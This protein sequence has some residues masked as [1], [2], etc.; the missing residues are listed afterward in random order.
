MNCDRN[1]IYLISS[2]LYYC[3]FSKRKAF[4]QIG[5]L[6]LCNQMQIDRSVEEILQKEIT[7][8]HSNCI[9]FNKDVFIEPN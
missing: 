8:S 2:Q 1:A 3:P 6:L 5:T 7:N 4:C 9:Y